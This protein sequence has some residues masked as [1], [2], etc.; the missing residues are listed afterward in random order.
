MH[1]QGTQRGI[2]LLSFIIV[3][4]VVGFFGF[5]IMRLFPTY[6]EYYSVVT[7][8]KSLAA[9]PGIA[10]LPPGQ[11]KDRLFK[12]MYISYVKSVKPENV[13]IVRK[14]GLLLQVKYDVQKPLFSNLDYVAKFDKTVPLR[15]SVEAE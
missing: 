12:R 13:R 5:L 14:D 15:A 10:K 4:A 6:S 11:I 9:E 8:M 3:L 7:S 1:H 2:T